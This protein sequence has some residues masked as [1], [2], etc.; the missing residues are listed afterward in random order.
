[1]PSGRLMWRVIDSEGQEHGVSQNPV[2]FKNQKPVDNEER[3]DL[4]VHPLPRSVPLRNQD[5]T[6]NVVRSHADPSA[7]QAAVPVN[8]AEVTQ[9][10]SNNHVADQRAIEGKESVTRTDQAAGVNDQN[11]IGNLVEGHQSKC[12][13]S[14]GRDFG[15]A[16]HQGIDLRCE[17]EEP[18]SHQGC[19]NNALADCFTPHFQCS[20]CLTRS[21]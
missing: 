5:R 17:D 13:N 16:M 8:S 14:A 10:H 12:G 6:E 20:I 21:E 19:V 18:Q 3:L 2:P 4:G 9:S 7:R 11:R 15:T 1:M